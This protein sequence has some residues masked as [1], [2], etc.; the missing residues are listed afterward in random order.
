MISDVNAFSKKL[1]LWKKYQPIWCLKDMLQKQK[2]VNYNTTAAIL[3]LKFFPVRGNNFRN[4]SNA[5][6]HY[7]HIRPPSFLKTVLWNTLKKIS[8]QWNGVC[9]IPK[10]SVAETC[11]LKFKINLASS[12]QEKVSFFGSCCSTNEDTVQL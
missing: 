9:S 6:L 2:I 4:L 8:L 3:M 7:W 12:L 5:K 11:R 10:W 1:E